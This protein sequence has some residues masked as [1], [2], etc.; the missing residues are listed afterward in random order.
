[1][2][3]LTDVQVSYNRVN[4]TYSCQNPEILNKLLKEELGF[5]G[6]VVSDWG[7]THAGVAAIMAGLDMTMPGG[8]DTSDNHNTSFFGF[9]L[10][11]AVNNGSLPIA[12]L[13]DM[14]LRT[15]TPYFQLDQDNFPSI[16]PS[17]ADLFAYDPSLSAFEWNLTGAAHRDAREDH[18]S[19]IRE[20]AASSTVLLKNINGA[21]PLKNAPAVIG[22]YGNDAADEVDGLYRPVDN[23]TNDFG[24]KIGTFYSGGG[25]SDG[26]LTYLVPPLQ[27]IK[28]WGETSGSLVQYILDN[29]AVQKSFGRTYPT[30]DVCF[31]FLKTYVGEG[32][33]RT[34][35]VSD[36][37]GDA[38]VDMV[39]TECNNTIVVTH[40]GGVN[41][42]KW[43]DNPNVTAILA[44]H[45]PGQE[46]GNSI[47]D[48]ITGKVNPSGR[49]TYTIAYN[50]SDYN[51]PIVNFTGTTDPNAWQSDF[52]EGLNI[53]YRHFD[54][55]DIQPRYEFGFGLSYTTFNMSDLQAFKTL[56]QISPLPRRNMSGPT[57]GGNPSLYENIANVQTT[58]TNTGS[59]S[60]ATVPQLYL[61]FPQDSTPPG[62]P[63][64]VLRG[65]DKITLHPG[66][67]QVVNFDLTRKD[68]SF[69]NTTAQDWQIPAGDF[70]IR[71]GF[72]SRDL[73]AETTLSFI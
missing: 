15:M 30:P 17:S 21:L 28:A 44:A 63:P 8:V 6:Y 3:S 47:L 48:V 54:S 20:L 45:I 27:A 57:P 72:S 32:T 73:P 36:W 23:P 26:R 40:A 52:T 41:T 2:Y 31:V 29:N 19:F 34:S 46:T 16:D 10:T 68:L 33:D 43:A 55:A 50:E 9:N 4:E 14:I 70:G 51:A 61:A 67:S 37:N 11:I 12:R 53:D 49:L 58:I 24:F 1:M 35:F 56:T 38:V 25:S 39:T 18:G 69:W 7:A 64:H 5:Q 59:V 22:V 13:D 62:T 71:C 60:G 65:F 66:E 42:L